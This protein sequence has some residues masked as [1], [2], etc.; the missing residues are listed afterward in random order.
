MGPWVLRTEGPWVMEGPNDTSPTRRQKM[1]PDVRFERI[2]PKQ[3]FTNFFSDFSVCGDVMDIAAG[4]PLFHNQEKQ[5]A[6][7]KKRT[8]AKL[9]FCP[10]K[11][12]FAR[13]R[14]MQVAM[15]DLV[16]LR[17]GCVA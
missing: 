3:L 10:K 4:D 8:R 9:S 2:F 17:V 7:A 1:A 5:N 13:Q 6:L 14:R 12:M 16:A 15:P 11:P